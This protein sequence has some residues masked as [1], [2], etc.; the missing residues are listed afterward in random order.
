MAAKIAVV[1]VAQNRHMHAVLR[2]DNAGDVNF[3]SIQKV[4]DLNWQLHP[5]WRRAGP[6]TSRGLPGTCTLLQL[7]LCSCC[8]LQRRSATRASASSTASE[9]PCGMYLQCA[10]SCRVADMRAIANWQAKEGRG[11]RLRKKVADNVSP[12]QHSDARRPCFSVGCCQS[13]SAVCTPCRLG[14]AV[15]WLP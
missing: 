12:G 15:S 5:S 8:L 13:W 11:D 4:I 1:H 2:S 6:G 3:P 7:C 9:L 10:T 14:W